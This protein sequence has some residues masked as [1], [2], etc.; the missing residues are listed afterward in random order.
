MVTLTKMRNAEEEWVWEMGRGG[1]G[2]DNEF[3]F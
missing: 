1:G 3:S 2:K